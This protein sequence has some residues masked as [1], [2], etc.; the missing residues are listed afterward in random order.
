MMRA[1]R[2]ET[3]RHLA[4]LCLGDVALNGTDSSDF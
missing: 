3:G 1:F 2:I 4:V